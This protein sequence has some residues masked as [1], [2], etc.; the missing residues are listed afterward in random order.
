MPGIEVHEGF[1]EVYD[2]LAPKMWSALQKTLVSYIET[3]QYSQLT[4]FGLLEAMSAMQRGAG[5]WALARC[6]S[7]N[8]C[9][10]RVEEPHVVAS[11]THQL[12]L[13]SRGYGYTHGMWLI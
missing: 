4:G 3:A 13:S 6:S 10:R 1:L 7:G 2:S 5:D 9:R 8:H 11:Q 12:R